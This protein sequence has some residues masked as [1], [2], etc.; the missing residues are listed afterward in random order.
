M[1]EPWLFI[2]DINL[3]TSMAPYH[4]EI[5]PTPLSL[6]FAVHSL[7]CVCDLHVCLPNLVYNNIY[8]YK[9]LY[10]VVHQDQSRSVYMLVISS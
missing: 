1:T 7:D 5:S 9:I 6:C 4:S 3:V 2:E 8:V 10:S